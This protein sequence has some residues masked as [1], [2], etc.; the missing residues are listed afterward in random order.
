MKTFIILSLLISQTLIAKADVLPTWK[1][2]ENKQAIIKFVEKVIDKKSP[3]YVKPEDRIATFDNDG[4]LWSEVPTVEVEFTKMRLKEMIQKDPKLAQKEPYKSLVM[5]K[6][7]P[8]KL[9]QKEMMEV[10]ATTHA[11]MNENEFAQSVKGFFQQAKHPKL[12]VPYTQTAYKP[13]LE[14]IS[15]LKENEF[16]VFICSGGDTSF[17]RVVA[18]EIYG[19]PSQN[20]IGT[21][22][23]DKTVE[24]DG[25]L[26][27]IRTDKLDLLNDKEGKPVGINR[28]IGKRPIFAAGNV[29]SG[30]DIDHL[31]YSKEGALPSLQLMINHDDAKR[32]S[33][34]N[35]KDNQS[36]NMAKKYGWKIISI[37]DDWGDVFS[38]TKVEVSTNE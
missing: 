4:T 17:M 14:L 16:S 36:L 10:F 11:G 12:N 38:K 22:L 8:P 2:G 20:I 32:E 13:M 34:Y 25:K 26:S 37:K 5:H 31:R 7:S 27:V 15:Y 24:K 23:K 18:T 1:D 30:G 6:K 9:N 28:Q 29:R 35:E 33:A 21:S 3:E 19:I